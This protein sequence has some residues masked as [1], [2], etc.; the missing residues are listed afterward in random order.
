MRLGQDTSPW[1]VA[2]EVSARI[3]PRV[4]IGAELTDLGTATGETRGITFDSKGEQRERAIAGLLRV[5]TAASDRVALDLIGGAGALFQR[6]TA[7]E[8]SCLGCPT[9]LT[10]KDA[11]RASVLVAGADVPVRLGDHFSMAG[12]A[13]YYVM[14]RGDNTPEDPRTPIRW[15]FEHESSG[16]L[17]VGGSARVTW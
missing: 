2:G 12:V 14:R 10:A 7:I 16:R 6:H 4:A 13:R 1:V 11:D 9:A 8:A 5:R 3:A 17:S 15:Q